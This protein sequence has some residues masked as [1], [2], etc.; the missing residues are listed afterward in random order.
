M[1][2]ERI[3]KTFQCGGQKWTVEQVDRLG[4]NLLGE[5]RSGECK[6]LIADK[7]NCNDT[8]SEDCKANTF[9]H[10]LIHGILGNIGYDELNNDHK[11]VCSFA[12]LLT[13]AMRDAVFIV[14]E[15]KG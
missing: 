7:Y 13:E 6:V 14:R 15:D 9:F 3:P 11:F 2:F 10:E 4:D 8:Q 12:A 1:N 5:C